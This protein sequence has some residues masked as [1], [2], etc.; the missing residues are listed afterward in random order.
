MFQKHKAK[1]ALYAAAI[2][3]CTPFTAQGSPPQDIKNPMEQPQGTSSLTF[4]TRLGDN[5]VESF[6]DL[7]Y[8]VFSA[9]RTVFFFNPRFSLKNE[10]ANEANVGVGLR[11]MLT[12]WLA[13]G[14]NLYFDSRESEYGNR[15]NQWGTGI[16]LLSDYVDVRANYYDADNSKERIASYTEKSIHTSTRTSYENNTFASGNSIFNNKTKVVQT[17][18]TETNRLFEQFEAGMDGW[19]AEI[20]CRLPFS[21]G[22]EIRLFAGYY[23]YDNPV[24]DDFSGSKG[25][26]E[27]KTGSWLALDAEV[28]EDKEFNDTSYF[29]GFRLQVPLNRNLSW[30]SFKQGLFSNPHRNLNQR[31][32]SA[33]VVRDVRVQTE[34]SGWQENTSQRR[35]TTR[36]STQKSRQEQV[37]LADNVTFVDGDGAGNN[38]TVFVYE[39]GG[40]ATGKPG[41][42]DG[43][44][45]YNESVVMLPGQTLT[46]SISLG[47]T[48]YQTRNL[49]SIVGSGWPETVRMAE[50][51]TVRRMKVVSDDGTCI[52]A[53][54]HNTRVENNELLIKDS[55]GAGIAVFA[56][57]SS[58]FSFTAMNNT[59][60]INGEVSTGI[61]CVNH[62]S[63]NV[64][65]TALENTIIT[66]G[67][68]SEGIYF[69][70]LMANMSIKNSIN[71]N[72]LDIYGTNAQPSFG[73]A[74]YNVNGFDTT[75]LRNDNSFTLRGDGAT[76]VYTRP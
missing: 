40:T 6:V 38:A 15:F 21:K 59:I 72:H 68:N 70:A 1:H 73:I 20:G 54:H 41:D 8:P 60:T 44:G 10:G 36:V 7:I 27:V 25:R 39:A 13:G 66:N 19:D 22:P 74:I 49:P 52:H 17:T 75:Q 71:E 32:R 12:D 34:D 30:Q 51:S 50:N 76:D 16:E 47:S 62:F 37:V 46:S 63:T 11:Y 43:G 53:D 64:S 24:G 3:L 9:D 61:T 45:S 5:T 57:N 69:L 28:F 18:A 65:F 2:A 42:A 26:L 4:G 14:A 31:M 55:M 67:V 33:M 48:S 35:V 56:N 58:N 29:L 23:D